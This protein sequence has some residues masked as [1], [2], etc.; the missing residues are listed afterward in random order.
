MMYRVLILFLLL[1]GNLAAQMT[2]DPWVSS[3]LQKIQW[4]KTFKGV[5]ADYHPVTI[6]LAS[7]HKM[8]AGYFIHEGDQRRHRLIGDWSTTDRFQLQEWDEHDKLSGY[9]TGIITHDLV[10]M[11]WMSADQSR[12]FH[13][14]AFPSSLIR[15]KNFKSVAEIIDINSSPKVM[16]SVQKMDY[17][18]VS[19]I[20]VRYGHYSRFEGYCL[21]GTCSIWNTVI[22]NPGGAPIRVQMRQ[23]DAGSYRVTFNG[24][25]YTGVIRSVTPMTVRQFD[26]STGFMDLAFPQFSGKTFDTWRSRWIEKIWADGIQHLN[27]MSREERAGRL[28]HRSS[29]WIEILD[30]SDQF[31]SGLVTYINP[32]ATRREPFLWLKKEDL[33]LTQEDWLATPED[34]RKGSAMALRHAG[35]MEDDVFRQWVQQTGYVFGLPTH[36]GILMVTEFS[37]VYGDDLRLIPPADS[38][39]LIRKKY[40]KY[41][42][43]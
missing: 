28:I 14:R 18:L 29:G 27:I 35:K 40:W 39:E 3:Q 37:M 17:G 32:G 1:C 2:N 6:I 30:E 33:F 10:Q 8:V 22:Q 20:A 7:D 34:I 43:W 26:G 4:E 23:K 15:I 41:F 13:V 38:K 16:I 19:G 42:G 5:L 24:T 9:L 25:D 36:A 12:I 31:V 21:D 11:D